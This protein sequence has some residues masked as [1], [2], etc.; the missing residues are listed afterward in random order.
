MPAPEELIPTDLSHHCRCDAVT[1]CTV[2][3]HPSLRVMTALNRLVDEMAAFDAET[4]ARS[5]LVFE[6]IHAAGVFSSF[7]HPG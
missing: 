4:G 6:S 2:F 5:R 7:T 1:R 3:T